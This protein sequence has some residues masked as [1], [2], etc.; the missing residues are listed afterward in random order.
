MVRNLFFLWFSEKK[1]K[2]ISNIIWKIILKASK[3]DSTHKSSIFK[4]WKS[5]QYDF[6]EQNFDPCNI[7]KFKMR[8]NLVW[9]ICHKKQTEHYSKNFT[10]KCFLI[11]N[12]A[13]YQQIFRILFDCKSDF[14]SENVFWN[15]VFQKLKNKYFWYY[16]LHNSEL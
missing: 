16:I 15:Y 11:E 13:L 8:A 2:K 1:S 7:A 5:K 3:N 10:S 12:G 4:L 9:H 14:A 6:S